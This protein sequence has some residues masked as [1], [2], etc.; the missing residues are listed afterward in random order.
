[1]E[2]VVNCQHLLFTETWRHS[3]FGCNLCKI[4]WEKHPRA[5]IKVVEGSEI[6]N[7]PIRHFVHFYSNF[8]SFLC[9]NSASWINW[10]TIP[11]RRAGQRGVLHRCSSVRRRTHVP[12]GPATP[13]SSAASLGKFPS[14]T[15]SP[16]HRRPVARR[17][18]HR[19]A[20]VLP[21][22]VRVDRCRSPYC[23]L[24][25]GYS[26]TRGCFHSPYVP[27]AIKWPT[28]PSRI[29]TSVGL[30]SRRI[31]IGTPAV[32]SPSACSPRRTNP[33]SPSPHASTLSRVAGSHALPPGSPVRKP[34]RP[35]PPCAWWPNTP[36]PRHLRLWPRT[37]P[38]RS[39]GHPPPVPGRPRRRSS[40][41]S[42]R[43][44]RPTSPSATLW[45]PDSFQGF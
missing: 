29:H 33:L 19:S 44:C 18:A 9:S 25:A 10:V 20:V 41:E 21:P 24:K 16:R 12:S 34:P 15:W 38:R 37:E 43:P 26:F 13:G 40:P 22:R 28:W 5:F 8:W 3:K 31:A 1:M 39:S 36:E 23:G 7:F 4:R 35:E 17:D 11:R 14:A 30:L 27:R 42:R 6:Y 32:S 2:N 45:G